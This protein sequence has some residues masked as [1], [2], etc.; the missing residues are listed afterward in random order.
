M[1]VVLQ[2]FIFC[3]FQ[4]STRFAVQ[5]HCLFNAVKYLKIQYVSEVTLQNCCI[6]LLFHKEN[7]FS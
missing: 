3:L 1:V 2:F 5:Y 4:I 7:M 6:I